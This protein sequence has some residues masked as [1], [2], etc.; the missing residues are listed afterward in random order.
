MIV[1]GRYTVSL[2]LAM[3]EILYMLCTVYISV[4]MYIQVSIPKLIKET[5]ITL[6]DNICFASSTQRDNL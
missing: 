5:Q 1:G 4:Y 3:N 6:I 2:Q